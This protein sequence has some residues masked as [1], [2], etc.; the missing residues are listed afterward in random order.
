[1]SGDLKAS[2]YFSELGMDEKIILE[3]VLKKWYLR[4]WDRSM[5]F[6]IKTNGGLL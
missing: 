3:C 2:G 1:L 6:G 5:W 4:I